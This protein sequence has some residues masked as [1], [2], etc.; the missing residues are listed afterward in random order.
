MKNYLIAILSLACV[1]VGAADTNIFY[2]TDDGLLI[3]QNHS[4]GF[5]M[6][7]IKVEEAKKLKESL[8]ATA[9]PEGNWGNAQGGFQLSIRFEKQTYVY[10]EPI[11]ATI[12]VR[13]VTNQVLTYNIINVAGQDSPIGIIVTDSK[14]KL[15]P[16]KSDEINIISSH[17]IKLFPGTQHKYQ[18]QFDTMFNLQT[19]NIIVVSAAFKIACPHCIE[20]QSAKVPIK[21]K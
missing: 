15:V 1:L 16:Q 4:G 2:V 12:L 14:G 5:K 10:G 13:N 21:I 17:E 3:G 8:P 19:N 6:N 18:E 7:P 20:I 9:F 11:I